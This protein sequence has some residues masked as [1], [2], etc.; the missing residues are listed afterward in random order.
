MRLLALLLS[1]WG[2]K[3]LNLKIG[4]LWLNQVLP[5]RVTWVCQTRPTTTQLPDLGRN[6]LTI[7]L[8][9]SPAQVIVTS[10]LRPEQVFRT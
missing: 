2:G 3:I 10:I 6:G 1:S 9:V 5:I 8:H 7:D 4:Q